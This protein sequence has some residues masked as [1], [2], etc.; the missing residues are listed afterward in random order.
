M[1]DQVFLI[2]FRQWVT[3]TPGGSFNFPRALAAALQ[4][5]IG[6]VCQPLCPQPLSFYLC[7]ADRRGIALYPPPNIQAAVAAF[8]PVGVAGRPEDAQQ[9]RKARDYFYALTTYVEVRG[10]LLQIPRPLL[11]HASLTDD[12]GEVV[13]TAHGPY[14]SLR[15]RDITE[16]EVPGTIPKEARNLF[17]HSIYP[18]TGPA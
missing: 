3:V 9:E 7:P 1:R 5:E 15:R 2:G 8:E 18:N 6:R 14:L 13:L 17:D 11:E 12:N 10:T 16:A 4:Q